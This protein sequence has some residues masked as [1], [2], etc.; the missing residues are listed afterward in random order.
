MVN[1][2]YEISKYTNQYRKTSALT[3]VTARDHSRI[4][5]SFTRRM[6]DIGCAEVPGMKYS[7]DVNQPISKHPL[8]VSRQLVTTAELAS[9][10]RGD[11]GHWVC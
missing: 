5:V 1:V 10:L 3:A 6:T 8:S 9:L 2:Q 11:G 4:G 7:I